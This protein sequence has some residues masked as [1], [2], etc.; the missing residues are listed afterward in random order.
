MNSI[1][2][3]R[4]EYRIVNPPFF[5]IQLFADRTVNLHLPLAQLYYNGN[6][7]V[8]TDCSITNPSSHLQQYTLTVYDALSAFVSSDLPILSGTSYWWNSSNGSGNT[9]MQLETLA[10]SGDSVMS[11]PIMVL[12]SRA[13]PF[14]SL[15]EI[16][17]ERL[18]KLIRYF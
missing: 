1:R 10:T 7:E 4:Y 5:C 18:R 2:S 12:M 13:G 16:H 6:E 11:M 8:V 3:Y 14:H 17:S 15:R 9:E